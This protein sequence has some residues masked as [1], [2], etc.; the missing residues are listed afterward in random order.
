V[1]NL[2]INDFSWTHQKTEV[3]GQMTSPKSGGTGAS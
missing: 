1:D 2:K 3:A